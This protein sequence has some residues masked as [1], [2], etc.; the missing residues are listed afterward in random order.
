MTQTHGVE[1]L[2]KQVITYLSDYCKTELSSIEYYPQLHSFDLR[3]KVEP[4]VGN[5]FKD[6]FCIHVQ[7]LAM[8]AELYNIIS[9]L[10]NMCDDEIHGTDEPVLYISFT[11]KYKVSKVVHEYITNNNIGTLAGIFKQFPDLT[12]TI[13]SYTNLT[14]HALTVVSLG[15]RNFV[16]P[17][18][19]C[20]LPNKMIELLK[21][22]PIF[23][24]AIDVDCPKKISRVAFESPDGFK[25]FF[26]FK[27]LATLVR[28]SEPVDFK[29]ETT[30]KNATTFDL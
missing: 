2:S 1:P 15:Y 26:Q 12:F 9:E 3:F 11:N 13:N 8:N 7:R 6:A 17:S 30:T 5:A 24:L 22:Y 16:G 28:L 29:S 14:Q 25:D 23:K 21:D 10:V 18:N 20:D 4:L 27:Y 19:Y